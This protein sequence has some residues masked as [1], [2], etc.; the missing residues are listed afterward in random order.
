M[1][2]PQHAL[3]DL[4]NVIKRKDKEREEAADRGNDGHL[5]VYFF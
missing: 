5:S 4:A 2:L 3:T 1:L